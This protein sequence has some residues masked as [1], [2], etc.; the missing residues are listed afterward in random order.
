MSNKNCARYKII[1]S[2]KKIR[3]TV[4]NQNGD[5]MDLKT[6]QPY[7]AEQVEIVPQRKTNIQFGIH[8]WRIGIYLFARQYLKYNSWFIF[9]GVSVDAV[10]G[11]DRYLDV[12]LKVLFLGFGVRFIWIKRKS[13]INN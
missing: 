11:Y 5:V 2:G 13:K 12:E 9:P 10:N 3:A 8:F 6:G 7:K 1:E 4:I